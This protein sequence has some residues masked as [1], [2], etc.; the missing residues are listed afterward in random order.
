[1]NPSRILVLLP[2]LAGATLCAFGQDTQTTLQRVSDTYANLKS[3]HFAGA[4]LAETK[5]GNSVSRSGT[6]FDVAM[7]APA[8]LRVEYRYEHAGNWVRVSD[9]KTTS[10]YRSLTKEFKRDAAA[11]EDLDILRGTP[12]S[13]FE[14]IAEGVKKA[15]LLPEETVAVG[16]QAVPCLVLE[17]EYPPGA[18]LAG[19]V[20]IPTR[21]WID[22]SRNI[23]LKQVTGTRSQTDDASRRTENLRTTTFTVAS[24]NE[25]VPDTLFAFNPPGKGK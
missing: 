14:H 20:P 25:D 2:A 6:E 23:I 21:Y 15:T 4:I 18:L 24:I 16:G 11:P 10:R 8:K 13:S 12:V 9:G 1:M 19:M 5:A 7:S 3:Y 22:K 17:V